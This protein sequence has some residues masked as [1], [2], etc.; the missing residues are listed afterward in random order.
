[1]A[2]RNPKH[3]RRHAVDPRLASRTAQPTRT[4][5][6]RALIAAGEHPETIRA[7]WRPVALAWLAHATRERY[8]QGVLDP[9]ELVLAQRLVE[10]LGE[11]GVMAHHRCRLGDEKKPKAP[12]T[13]LRAVPGLMPA[14][15][16]GR[17]RHRA[18]Q[19]AKEAASL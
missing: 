17:G 3:D 8:E 19:R 7:D 6:A 14:F 9:D 16:R 5:I 10:R 4:D 15:D 1:M 2:Y 11:A 12:L 13:N 18:Y